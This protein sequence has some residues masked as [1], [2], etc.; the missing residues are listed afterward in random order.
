L[1]PET[2]FYLFFGYWLCDDADIVAL[3]RKDVAAK[4]I[5]SMSSGHE[6]SGPVGR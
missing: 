5:I 1:S 2:A 4:P 3:F 6:A